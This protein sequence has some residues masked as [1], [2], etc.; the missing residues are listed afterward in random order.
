MGSSREE[1]IGADG[2]MRGNIN[3]RDRRTMRNNVNMRNLWNNRNMCRE[4]KGR[5]LGNNK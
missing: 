3:L 4:N 5:G 1:S 2:R